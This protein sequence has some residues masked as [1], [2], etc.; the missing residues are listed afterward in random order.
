MLS[1]TYWPYE[2]CD[3]INRFCRFF[4][5]KNEQIFVDFLA[6][7]KWSAQLIFGFFELSMSGHTR[8]YEKYNLTQ[9]DTTPF[10]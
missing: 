2:I 10:T 6:N 4:L 3:E 9:F 5:I 7:K 8:E 1:S